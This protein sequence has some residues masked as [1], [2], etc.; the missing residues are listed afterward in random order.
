[1]CISSNR[2]MRA[3]S[4]FCRFAVYSPSTAFHGRPMKII[5]YF[6]IGIALSVLLLAADSAAAKE[7]SDRYQ[8]S[9]IT[10]GPGQE[11]F[12]RFGHIGLL[13]E[14]KTKKT[15]KV[16]NFGM[17]N[18]NNPALRFKYL[19]GFLIYWV[20]ARE[21]QPMIHVYRN[22]DR[23][24]E[25]RVLHLAPDAAAWLAEKLAFYAR[26]ENRYYQY[27]H[28]LNNCCTRIR[29]LID[30]A[31]EGAIAAISK[32]KMNDR[33]YRDL[34]RMSLAGT[35]TG[36]IGVDFILGPAG[37][38][39]IDR[40]AEEFLPI[41]LAE[42]LDKAVSSDGAPLVSRMIVLHE[43]KGPPLNRVTEKWDIPVLATLLVLIA[44]GLATPILTGPIPAPDRGAA[45]GD[46]PSHM[47]HHRRGGRSDPRLSLDRDDALRLSSQREPAL[48][49]PDAPV[50]YHPGPLAHRS[51]QDQRNGGTAAGALSRPERRYHRRRPPAQTQGQST[52][53]LRFYAFLFRDERRLPRRAPAHGSG[54]APK[55]IRPSREFVQLHSVGSPM[56]KRDDI[57][58][59]RIVWSLFSLMT[60]CAVSRSVTFA[61]GWDHPLLLWVDA[62]LFVFPVLFLFLIVLQLLGAIKG[63]TFLGLA[64]IISSASELAAIHGLVN[65]FGGAYSYRGGS[66]QVW[67]LPIIVPFYWTG[68][69]FMG[70]SVVSAG[71]AWTG[72]SKPARNRSGIGPLLLLVLLDG[73]SV[74]AVDMCMDP[75]CVQAGIW[76]WVHEG[77]FF[78]VPIGNFV[79]WF[80][81]TVLCT[82]LFRM[83]EYLYPTGMSKTAERLL[84]IPVLGYGLLGLG[85][86]LQTII[87]KTPSILALLPFITIIPVFLVVLA[88]YLFNQKKER[89][90]Q[91]D[92]RNGFYP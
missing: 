21:F 22:E 85:F 44:L 27:R 46:R 16:Y 35:I 60:I 24:V 56:K 52:E 63:M 68:F 77:C 29:D 76:T 48:L 39:P 42:D 14:D 31:S 17:Y 90:M 55:A 32:G 9:V 30:E 8:I 51:R 18:F 64:F 6:T 54:E 58:R 33:T 67:G 84:I 71:Y 72:R 70:Y 62:F 45:R 59:V 88:Q 5:Q 25:Q 89:L 41:I 40:W 73:L 26:P 38:K 82:G 53:Q 50:P 2:L 86:F 13:V 78:G 91:F 10:V 83:L 81:V 66:L 11:L 3:A 69:I 92:R 20:S 36:A 49:P 19:K 28:F 87:M 23:M 57:L 15:E 79:G 74:V 37:D 61:F 75:I 1:M 80:L 4:L 12:S 47:G 65:L 34:T 43:R 7:E